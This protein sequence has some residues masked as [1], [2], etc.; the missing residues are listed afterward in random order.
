MSVTRIMRFRARS[1]YEEALHNVLLALVPAVANAPGCARVRLL[2]SLDDPR[3]FLLYEEWASVE[4]HKASANAI[5]PEIQ[6]RTA[7]LAENT[8]SG[9][10]YAG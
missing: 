7:S 1:G 3:D 5:M 4:A 6:S 9:D 10:Y 8:P 2:S